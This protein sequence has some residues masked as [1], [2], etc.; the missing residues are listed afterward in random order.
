MG[1]GIHFHILQ[2]VVH[3]GTMGLR[4][5]FGECAALAPCRVV[6]AGWF[7]SGVF[8]ASSWRWFGNRH[9][10]SERMAEEGSD[11]VLKR[12]FMAFLVRTERHGQESH[13]ELASVERR[14]GNSRLLEGMI[15]P[16]SSV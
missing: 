13:A 10:A 6:C 2:R 1:G 9:A 3:S 7:G 8:C 14:G 16:P 5:R 11:T 4:W 12:I 15:L